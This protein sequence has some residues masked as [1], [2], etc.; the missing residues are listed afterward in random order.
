MS[1]KCDAVFQGG[2]VKG[3]GLVGAVAAIE[4]AGYEFV[5]VAGSSAGAIVSALIAVGYDSDELQ[6]E[7]NR[8][9]Y[10]KLRQKKKLSKLGPPGNL[11]SIITSYGIYS[12]NY[13]EDWLE[14]LLQKK[15][16]TR[17]KDI[18]TDFEGEKYRY[19]FNAIASDI[20]DRKMLVLPGDLK[21]FGYDPDDFKIAKAVRMS[22]S[23]PVFF[24]PF[25]LK[26]IDGKEHIIVDGGLLSNYPI[27]LL[28][29]NS[30]NPPWPTIGF[31]FSTD[32]SDDSDQT[33]TCAQTNEIQNIFSY[34]MSLLQTMIDAHDKYHISNSNGD[35]ER[36]ILISN[37]LDTCNKRKQIS[38]TD[39]DITQ[40]EC[41]KLYSNGFSIAQKFLSTWNFN[42]WVKKYRV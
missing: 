28:D 41:E 7:L 14:S 23:I 5:N 24:E 17:F 11:L 19:K 10:L 36:T 30:N 13:F 31:K 34:L 25:K 20:T 27:W 37:K 32:T 35:F 26:D 38:T 8:L 33:D 2:G 18:K 6:V 42:D 21:R 16:K 12:A 22:M 4:K 39:F 15:N 29:D 1:L 9:D 40:D 3:I